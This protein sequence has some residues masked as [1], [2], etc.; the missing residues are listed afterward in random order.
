M[1]SLEQPRPSKF[2][3]VTQLCFL[4]NFVSRKK[5]SQKGEPRHRKPFFKKSHQAWYVQ[6]DGR[7]IRLSKDREEAFEK[8]EELKRQRKADAADAKRRELAGITV[9]ELAD[10]F[11]SN[12]FTGKSPRTRGFHIEKI[13]PLCRHLGGDFPAASLTSLTVERWISAHPDWSS[14]TARTIWQAV[15]AMCLW[16]YR[17]ELVP[18]LPL[19]DHRKP[20]ASKRETVISPKEY[21]R[22]RSL[23]R[24]DEFGALVDFAWETGARPQELWKMEV[25]HLDIANKRVVLGVGESKGKRKPRMIVLSDA[26]LEIAR[27]Q[28]EKHGSGHLFRNTQS[29][30]WTASSTNLAFQHLRKR[31]GAESTEFAVS[32]DEVEAF[33]GGASD[34]SVEARAKARLKIRH[35][36][37]NSAAPKY[38]FYDFRHSWLD[39]MLKSGMDVLTAAIL[40]GHS[41]P[42]MVARQYQHL[43]QSPEYLRSALERATGGRGS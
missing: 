37:R 33:L 27:R 20:A 8:F 21:E 5:N 13:A 38:C 34:M 28:A 17:S 11:F 32:K 42:S 24:N 16:G 9:V 7:Q 25:R 4:E 12:A 15:K 23:I 22:L 14:G 2:F 6:L 40:M 26:A 19:L 29:R 35:A 36:R 10:Q 30:P 39:R 18:R 31:M 43:S 1:G 3:A 41:D